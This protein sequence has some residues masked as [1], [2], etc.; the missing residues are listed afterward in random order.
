ME[1]NS[2]GEFYPGEEETPLFKLITEFDYTQANLF[3]ATQD[4]VKLPTDKKMD[5][6]NETINANGSAFYE[7]INEIVFTEE[8]TKEEKCNQITGLLISTDE[9]RVN[10]FRKIMPNGNFARM[11]ENHN[12]LNEKINKRFDDNEDLNN[13]CA[14]IMSIYA[15]HLT[16][17]ANILFESVTAGNR[18]KLYQYLE[19]AKENAIQVGA[20]SLGVAIGGIIANRVIKK[21]DN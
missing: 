21:L 17:D 16:S 1:A 12:S 9:D 18:H 4:L 19:K 3:Q 20:L 14:E 7:V 6:L 5:G 13:V 10:H 8:T 11:P 15:H 2:S